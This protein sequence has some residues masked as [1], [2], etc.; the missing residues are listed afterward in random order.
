MVED[1][2]EVALPE[3]L[4]KKL[5]GQG[6]HFVG[7]HSATKICG[8]AS[9]SLKGGDSCYK[10]QFYGISSWRCMQATPALGC[11]LAC[12]FCWRLIPEEE[13]YKWNELNAV[14]DW[15]EPGKIVDGIVEQH[16]NIITGY[17]GNEKTVLSRW[18]ES[19]APAHAAL[20]LAGEPLFYPKM[21]ELL[22]AFHSRGISTFVVTN[23]TM[24]G[25]LKK[26]K[27]MPTQM[28]VSVQAPNKEVYES[29]VRPKSLNSTWDNVLEFLKRFSKLK[30]RKAFRL[31]LV[32]GLNM[33]DA[34]GY[35]EL[36]KLGKPQ[37]VE[38]KGFVFVGGSRNPERGLA[39][40][41]MPNKKE[42]LDFASEIAKESGYR[43]TDYHESSKV[44][45]LCADD[46]AAKNRKIEFGKI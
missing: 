46:D 4:A 14:G 27:V 43:L 35:A 6:Y 2:T 31:T 16:R 36:I 10:H 41:Q 33:T 11:N 19:N 18:Q 9:R 40:E 3:G 24:V 20:S 23:G 12:K 28:Y 8:Y 5:A 30:T 44:A 22:S 39:Y 45:L 37:Y 25:A 34:K 15:D 29:T 42:I 21:N 38:V 1:R 32:R 17:K 13:G 26:L 7:R